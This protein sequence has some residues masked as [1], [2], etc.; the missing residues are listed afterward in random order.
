VLGDATP[1]LTTALGPAF[2]DAQMVETADA[3]QRRSSIHRMSTRPAGT[4]CG[5][6]PRER[7]GG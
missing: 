4:L 1:D 5:L 2:L 7:D 6:R 3:V